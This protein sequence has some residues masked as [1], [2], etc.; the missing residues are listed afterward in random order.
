MLIVFGGLPGTGKTTIARALASRIGAVYLR[1]D[2]LEQAF[3]GAVGENVDIGAA[4]YLAGYAVARDNLKLGLNVIADSVNALHVTRAAW[5]NVAASARVAIFEIE[6][7]CSDADIHRFR[8]EGRIA[9]IDRYMLPTWGSVLERHYDAW[10][11]EHMI[12]DTAIMSA[13]Q[14][15]GHVMHALS[16]QAVHAVGAA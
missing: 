8:V 14:A 12:I 7:I 10:S 16:S 2:S 5:R 6:V 3:I 1:I 11:S 4:G 9:D 13:E 15:V